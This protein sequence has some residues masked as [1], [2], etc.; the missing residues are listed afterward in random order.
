MILISYDNPSCIILCHLEDR[1][2]SPKNPQHFRWPA[3]ARDASQ[4]YPALQFT[5]SDFTQL[6]HATCDC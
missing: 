1:R 5:E 6:Q 3:D 2:E 4:L